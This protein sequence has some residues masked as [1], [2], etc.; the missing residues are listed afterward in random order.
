MLDFTREFK[1]SINKRL[2]IHQVLDNVLKHE[3]KELNTGDFIRINPSPISG[4]NN[5]SFSIGKYNNG[6]EFYTLFSSSSDYDEFKSLPEKGTAADLIS[7]ICKSFEEVHQL[8]RNSKFISLNKKEKKEIKVQK[9]NDI[10][11]LFEESLENMDFKHFKYYKSIRKFEDE[12]I[13]RF[14]IGFKNAIKIDD[15]W[16]NYY[17]FP[18]IN[19]D[20]VQ[21][22]KYKLI[23]SGAP[24]EFKT[25]QLK[26]NNGGDYLFNE[27]DLNKEIIII[28]EGEHDAMRIWEKFTK[29]RPNFGV[30][31]L[32]GNPSFKKIKK[33]KDANK[34]YILAFDNDEQGEKYTQKFKL[35]FPEIPIITGIGKDPDEWFLNRSFKIEEYIC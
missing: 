17:S 31:A 32:G 11:Q 34:K 8:I 27:I 14:K 5:N 6:I 19:S 9:R 10:Q 22:I 2:T 25:T 12:T 29:N 28:C 13:S 23:E 35:I 1:D 7:C 33:I 20:G 4:K 15:R 18:Y 30:V 21:H 26:N 16:F 3:Y 24:K